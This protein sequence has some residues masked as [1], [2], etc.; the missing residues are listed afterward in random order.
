MSYINERDTSSLDCKHKHVAENGV[1]PDKF[2][3][4]Y[5]VLRIKINGSNSR[6]YAVGLSHFGSWYTFKMY[7]LL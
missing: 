5:R 6:I 1:P 3:V 4:L 7:G 2:G